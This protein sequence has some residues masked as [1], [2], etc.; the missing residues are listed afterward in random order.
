MVRNTVV[1]RKRDLI[2]LLMQKRS[3]ESLPIQVVGA[4]S[5]QVFR[6]QASLDVLKPGKFGELAPWVTNTHH[7]VVRDATG[8]RYSSLASSPSRTVEKSHGRAKGIGTPAG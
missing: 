7:G 2:R 3:N 6:Q 4:V 8:L 1:Q 5:H